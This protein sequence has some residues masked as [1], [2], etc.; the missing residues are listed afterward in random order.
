MKSG[1][2]RIVGK[3]MICAL[4]GETSCPCRRSTLPVG[5]GIAR[6]QAFYKK[7]EPYFSIWLFLRLFTSLN[8]LFFS[9]IRPI[10]SIEE[11]VA[12]WPASAEVSLW[13]N[14]V[15][16][17]PWLRWDAVWYV[18]L[19]TTGYAAGDGSTSFH[20]LYIWLSTPLYLLGAEPLFSLL[21]S[22]S[23]ASLGFFWIFYKLACLDL[24]PEKSQLALILLATFPIS[25]I[26]FAPYTE[27]LFLFFATLALYQMRKR[28]GFLAAMAMCLASLTR[29]QGV[30]LMF[31]MLWYAW[32]DSG[33]SFGG[34]FKAWRGWLAACTAPIGLFLWTIYRVY[35]LHEGILDMQNWQSFVYS[36]L[37]SPSAKIIFPD[38][39]LIWP[40]DA[41]A[42][43][44]SKLTHTPDIGD[45]MT[46]VLGVGFVI[47]FVLAWKY[48]NPAD[49][50]YTLVITLVSFSMSTGPI[51][52]YLSLPLHLFIAVP[53]FIGLAGAFKQRWQLEGLIGTQVLIQIFMLFLY[54]TK[55]WIP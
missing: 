30:L 1:D 14:R 55:S 37:L 47:L 27:S 2:D 25:I 10:T 39:A 43:A 8:A 54:V 3:M 49:R 40:W 42:I 50:I 51:R 31:P 46:L 7:I 24:P 16:L 15:F 12:V 26:L 28:R 11:E 45:V 19:L 32:E 38:Q 5:E 6:M 20:P 41:L 36:V 35:Y 21:I 33:K 44:I 18:H 52:I 22:S 23:L 9:A 17:A 13:L 34:V 29:Q 4:N 53:V 48:M